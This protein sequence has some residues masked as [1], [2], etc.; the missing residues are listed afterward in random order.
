MVCKLFSVAAE[1][2]L[3]SSPCPDI[4]GRQWQRCSIGMS[5]YENKICVVLQILLFSEF[6][7]PGYHRN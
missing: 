2:S 3:Q 4:K 7:T 5:E 6:D 1:P